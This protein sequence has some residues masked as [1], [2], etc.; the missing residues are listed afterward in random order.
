[1]TLNDMNEQ[2]VTVKYF[3]VENIMALSQGE[4]Q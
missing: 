4:K 3:T 2:Q 1:M